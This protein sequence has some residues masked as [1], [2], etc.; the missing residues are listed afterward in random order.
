MFGNFLPQFSFNRLT[1]NCLIVRRVLGTAHCGMSVGITQESLVES[2]GSRF[3]LLQLSLNCLI[4][5]GVLNRGVFSNFYFVGTTEV[6]ISFF[7]HLIL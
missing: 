4:V 5:R 3:F 7:N 1:V 2:S 6:S